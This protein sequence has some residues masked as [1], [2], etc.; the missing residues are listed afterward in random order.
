M[1]FPM[2][3][4]YPSFLLVCCYVSCCLPLCAQDA[5]PDS[6]SVP[7]APSLSPS[8][9]ISLRYDSHLLVAGRDLGV[10]QAAVFPSIS[11]YH[12]SGLFGTVQGNALIDEAWTYPQTTLEAGYLGRFLTNW[13]YSA[14]YQ[15]FWFHP[16]EEGLIRHGLNLGT[17]ATFGA[18]T[19]GSMASGL[20][21]E[22]QGLFINLYVSAYWGKDLKGWPEAIEAV[23]MTSLSMG[24]ENVPLRQFQQRQFE[25]GTGTRW[26]DRRQVDRTRFPLQQEPATEL[27]FGLMSW[28]LSLPVYLYQGPF[29]LE[30]TPSLAVP[31]SLPEEDYVELEPSFWVTTAVSYSF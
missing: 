27:S 17:D 12:P 15:Y 30:L 13:N 21:G 24:T 1:Q 5:L 28:D 11:Y 19:V 26:R 7:L 23:P 22:E 4:L 8:W 29:V 31:I 10:P 18:W 9:T 25:R 20:L 2:H 6:S 14:S 3:S 16:A